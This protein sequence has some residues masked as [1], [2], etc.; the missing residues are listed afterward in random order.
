MH[1]SN[2]SQYWR[3]IVKRRLVIV[4]AAV[5]LLLLSAAYNIWKAFPP[6]YKSTCT[7]KFVKEA[8]VRGPFSKIISWPENG[9]IETQQI[10]ITGY[11]LL[12]EVAR[13][14][15]LIPRTGSVSNTGVSAVIDALRA[16]IAFENKDTR[17]IIQI[18]VT[19][20]DP[21]FAQKMANTIAEI[22]S[23]QQSDRQQKQLGSC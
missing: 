2:F 23:R 14:L 13:N 1:Y 3:I 22:Y 7:V 5:L 18:S 17:N 6:L 12:F 8:S 21:S 9:D 10:I 15:S 20:S 19:D 16:K 4:C 11:D